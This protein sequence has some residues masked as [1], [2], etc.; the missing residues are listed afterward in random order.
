MSA[1]L[2]NL[3]I[4]MCRT[5][6]TRKLYFADHPTV[7]QLT[8]K[9]IDELKQF[10]DA[11]GLE[12]LFIGIV[13]GELVFEGKHLVGPTIIGAQFIDAATT[14][15]SGGISFDTNTPASEFAQFLSLITELTE[16]PG[17]LNAARTLL[18]THGIT[19]IKLGQRF[20]ESAT[21]LLKEEQ[22]IW[23]GQESDKMLSSPALIYQ[24]LFDTV[25]QAHNNALTGG[26][27]DLDHTRS[28]TE[29][30]LKRSTGNFSDMMQQVHYPDF[31]GYTIG[32]SVRVAALAVFMANAFG[33]HEDV[34][35]EVGSAALLHDIG[36]SG[37]P[38]NVLYKPGRLSKEEFAIMM[39]HPRIGAEILLAQ[40]SSTKLDV[41]IA[42]GHHIRHDGDGY[43]EQP[44]WA[45]R[46][47]ITSLL[48]VC[49]AFEALTAVRPYKPPLTPHTAF[50]VMLNDPGAFNPAI[51]AS[52]ITILGLYPPGTMVKLSDTSA[53]IVT[54]AGTTIDRPTV[55][56][57]TTPNNEPIPA[58][59]QYELNLSTLETRE[60]AIVELILPRPPKEGQLV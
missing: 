48:R 30:M 60:V 39:A 41:A 16:P 34:Q 26:A 45:V 17:D 3:L 2:N 50:S 24:M 4:L 37:I 6:S 59:D 40:D 10:C 27:V 44:Q 52:F 43:P 20:K 12:T 35:L 47:P 8:R 22:D 19:H 15:K 55:R 28:I 18:S 56:V 49:D 36:K 51:L 5:I 21:P 53:G 31:E 46:H 42:W 14:L 7:T 11:A 54:A 1:Q 38:H 9:F 25:A 32:H 13:D 29:F 57:T 33:W 58:R 23:R